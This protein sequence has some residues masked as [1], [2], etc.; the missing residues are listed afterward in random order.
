VNARYAF[1]VS[2]SSGSGVVI[3]FLLLCFCGLMLPKLNNV[4]P[5]L[6]VAYV[7]SLD[8]RVVRVFEREQAAHG[9]ESPRV[10]VDFSGDNDV[11]CAS[12]EL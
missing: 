8:N 11:F 9:C 10:L 7:H 3:L 12:R 1:G 4:L 2:F 5:E 6:G